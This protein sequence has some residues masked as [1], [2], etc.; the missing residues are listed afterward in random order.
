MAPRLSYAATMVYQ[1]GCFALDPD[2]FE[3]RAE[4]KPVPVEPQVLWLLL[5]LVQ[6]RGRL[7]TKQQL[8]DAVW[9]GRPV[10]DATLASRI[11]SVRRA[12]G[13][14]GRHGVHIHTVHGQGWRFEG[15]VSEEQTPS[16]AEVA[17]GGVSLHAVTPADPATA[18][19]RPSIA[20]LPFTS[21]G[22]P[23]KL[24]ALELALPHDLITEISR[25][26]WL[27]VIAR[28]SS[29]RLA[30]SPVA[31]AARLLGVRYVLRGT[32]E[33][34]HPGV[35]IGVELVDS[36]DDSVVWAERFAGPVDTVH[37]LRARIAGSLA[38]ALDIRI[39]L[40]EATQARLAVSEHLDAWSAYHL[41][42]QQMY[43]FDRQGN[44][45]AGEYFER[46]VA[47]DPG[48]ARAHAGL[49]FVHFQNAFLHLG[50]NR[51]QQVLAA[52]A[53]AERGLE[54]DPL[55]P[56][57]NFTMGRSFWLQ[58]DLETSLGW[59]ER[60]TQLSPNFAQGIYARGWAE[61]LS[62]AV[63]A[64]RRQVDLALQLS[65]IDPLHYAMLGTRALAHLIAG[66]HAASADWADRAARAP[67]AHV[68]ISMIAAVANRLA[69]R[70][71]AA[72]HWRER[73]RQRGPGLRQ[74]DFLSAFP[75]RPEPSRRAVSEA[76]GQL[77]F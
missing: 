69:G 77:G 55:D 27:F 15:E 65:P 75:I 66:E 36:A 51:E 26:R 16:A 40:H 60:A 57:V 10:A 28:G 74:A 2:R 9:A 3:F 6:R 46:A 29:F 12:L 76:L 34:A 20:V 67:G 64:G 70:E 1:F 71:G 42:L 73:V 59:L 23:G 8:V 56:F 41:G 37:E 52:R 63:E 62:G 32:I 18:G 25:L 53:A 33:V 43:R 13:E 35:I 38:T 7:V 22:S 58:G 39:P 47:L 50:A 24:A 17:S 61:T 68:M 45:A 48:F 31:E 72:H 4:G 5:A 19:G 44:G 11:R 21:I 30:G 14:E 54:L 49:S